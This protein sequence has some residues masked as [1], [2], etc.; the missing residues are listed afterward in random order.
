M[1][2]EVGKLLAKAR[3]SLDAARLL[4]DEGYDDF[5]A[6]RA[7]YSILARII[8]PMIVGNTNNLR[9]VVCQRW[10][11]FGYHGCSVC[12][13][14]DRIDST[15]MYSGVKNLYNRH[16]QETECRNAFWLNWM[17]WSDKAF[18]LPWRRRHCR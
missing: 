17:Q 14:I 6:S 10:G 9:T 13:V 18:L 2:E 8:C 15:T 16:E 11:R 1:S 4:L 5:A 7:Y 3:E 12:T